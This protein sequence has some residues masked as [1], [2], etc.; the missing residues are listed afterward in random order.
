[1]FVVVIGGSDESR[2]VAELAEKSHCRRPRI[3]RSSIFG[4][5]TQ[6]LCP[7]LGQFDSKIPLMRRTFSVESWYIKILETSR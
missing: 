7:S 3:L 2:S 1:M 5:N 6:K 4:G